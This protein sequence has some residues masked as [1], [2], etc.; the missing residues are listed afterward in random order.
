MSVEDKLLS[1]LTSV[2]EALVDNER[3]INISIVKSGDT[4]LVFTVDVA[5]ED[6][7]KLIGRQG[8]TASSI[9]QIMIAA[10]AKLKVRSIISIPDKR[11][12]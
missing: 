9:R 2:V 6:V 10:S 8:R 4:T 12:Q 5:K 3:A 7:G 1:T 11:D